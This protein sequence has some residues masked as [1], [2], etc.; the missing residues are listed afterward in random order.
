MNDGIILINNDKYGAPELKKMAQGFTMKG[1][2]IAVTLHIG[3]IAAY[4]L[5]VYLNESKAKDIPR[6]PNTIVNIVE[7]DSPPPVEDTDIPPVKPDE[8]VSKVKDLSSLQPEPV[9]KDIADDVVLKTQDQL[10]DITT[11]V[12]RTGDSVVFSDNSNIKVDDNV[13]KDKIDNVV[14]DPVIDIFTISEVDV[15]PE[16]INLAQV[17][18]SMDYPVLAVESQIQGRVTVKVLVGPDGSV[19]K[20]G[21]LTGPDIFYDEV[22]DKAKDLQFTPGLQSNKPVKVW[23]TVP[24][25][26]KLQ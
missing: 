14:K 9:R 2:I 6:N 4:M 23:V 17:K 5:F 22:K 21:S 13:I 24:F 15:V 25:N 26:F 20:T 10:N 7:I 18:A 3:L 16:A 8:P 19:I 1:F 12:S 11:G